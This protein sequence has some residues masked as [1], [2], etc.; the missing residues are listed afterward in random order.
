[1]VT[2]HR[3]RELKFETPSQF[4]MPKPEQLLNGRAVRSERSVVEL[5]STYYDTAQHSL[6][7]H[8]VTLRRREGDD[9]TGWHL[10]VPTGSARTEIKV[11]LGSGRSVPRRLAAMVAGLTVGELAPVATVKT[12]RE[13]TR[14][15]DGDRLVIELADDEVTGTALGA[16]ATVTKWHELEVELGSADDEA[17]LTD[18]AELL[19]AAGARPAEAPSKLARTLGWS[20]P[21]E[22]AGKD[23]HGLIVRY[24]GAQLG[25]IGS[26]DI[27]FR[28]G[29]DPVHKTRV[30]V[31]RFRSTLRV[32]GAAWLDLADARRLD[33]ELSWY[34]NVL[35]DVRDREVLRAR[36]ADLVDGLP[37]ELVL[38]PVSA[39]IEEKL[40]REQA[41]ARQALSTAMDSDRYLQLLRSVEEWATNPPIR[42]D[43]DRDDVLRMARKA[44]RTARKRLKKALAADSA[45]LLHR[46]RKAAKRARY[47]TELVAP[48]L[49]KP[50]SK[51]VAAY[52]HAQ[53][54][55][56]E[57]QD[58]VIA[59]AVL[60]RLGAAATGPDQNGFTFGLL[61]EQEQ[62]AATRAR[63]NAHDL[64][65]SLP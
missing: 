41:V 30:A 13:R 25:E 63:H 32:F 7:Q 4:A 44:Q 40:G 57:H 31:R 29:V 12:R 26:G 1:M 16:T 64:L 9:D 60:R 15:F 55:L 49:G 61:Y 48:A 20:D 36:F 33:A 35:G 18:V 56:G 8:R 2:T 28:R 34:Q 38:G 42:A 3:E 19:I 59:A 11:P 51:Q 24:L 17:L 62:A 53:D 21:I 39:M 52:K 22:S 50:A 58:S 65:A 46:A 23:A 6:L 47:A 37:V 27:A 5:E 54:T 14:V 43:V 10:K 45:E